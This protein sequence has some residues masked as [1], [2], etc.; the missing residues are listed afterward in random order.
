MKGLIDDTFKGIKL[1]LDS[2]LAEL[3]DYKPFVYEGEHIWQNF[4][5]ANHQVRYGH[6]ELF[7]SSNGGIKV[8]HC[9]LY[10]HYSLDCGIFGFDM[11]ALNGNITGIFCDITFLKERNTFLSLL[12]QESREQQRTLP[13]WADFF[14]PDFIFISLPNNTD[15]FFSKVNKVL[16]SYLKTD[17][18]KDYS[19]F[20]I[21][22]N[23]EKQNL[24]SIKQRQNPKTLKSLT[25]FIGEDKAREYIDK[26]MFPISS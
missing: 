5:Y 22:K 9:V 8:I 12:C 7:Q 19:P 21:S 23:I 17:I 15:D 10:P 3:D 24:Y 2:S 13:E 20:N 16:I 18:Y 4:F 25:A 1:I 26:V 11:I 14:S 6:L